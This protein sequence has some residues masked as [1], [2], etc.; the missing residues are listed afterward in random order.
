M[1]K[2]L[3]IAERRAVQRVAR[4]IESLPETVAL[5]FHGEDASVMRTDADGRILGVKEAGA[6]REDAAVESIRTHRCA[7]GDF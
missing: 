2:P 7:A 4:A 6:P 1:A 3:T 5:Y